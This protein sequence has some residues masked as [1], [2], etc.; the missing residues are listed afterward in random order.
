MLLAVHKA[1]VWN[2]MLPSRDT[3]IVCM[4]WYYFT[5]LS[6]EEINTDPYKMLI[7]RASPNLL[8]TDLRVAYS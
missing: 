4:F 2:L 3:I 6:P 5:C 1:P 7:R 8:Q